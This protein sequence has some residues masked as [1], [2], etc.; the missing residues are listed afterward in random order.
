[1]NEVWEIFWF[2][3]GWKIEICA[4]NKFSLSELKNM[5]DKKLK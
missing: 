3:L 1:M 5:R 4:I 2:G